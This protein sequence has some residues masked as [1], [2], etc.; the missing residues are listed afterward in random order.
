MTKRDQSPESP[1]REK[2]DLTDND[3]ARDTNQGQDQEVTPADT[4]NIS[5]EIMGQDQERTGMRADTVDTTNVI[6]GKE[7]REE[8]GHTP[9]RVR[10]WARKS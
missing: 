4:R 1:R 2:E 9:E 6:T 5:E 8:R 10:T 7:K 3:Q